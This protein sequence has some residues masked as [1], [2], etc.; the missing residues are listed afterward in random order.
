[1]FVGILS[2]CTLSNR[3]CNGNLRKPIEW[4]W[5]APTV[6]LE[7]LSALNHCSLDILWRPNL[8]N[9]VFIENRMV[10]RLS[11]NFIAKLLKWISDA[12]YVFCQ[13]INVWIHCTFWEQS[14]C[15]VDIQLYTYVQCKV[16]TRPEQKLTQIL[17]EYKKKKALHKFATN[18]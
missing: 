9:H 6:I 14:V 11:L 3:K 15:F 17:F 2:I 13:R 10:L 7:M 18:D 12:I 5:N 8:C 4:Q 16:H 1:M